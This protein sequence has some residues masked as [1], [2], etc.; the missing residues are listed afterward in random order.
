MNSALRYVNS[1]VYLLLAINIALKSSIHD[2]A[3]VG[4]Y[5]TLAALALSMGR[6]RS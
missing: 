4:L 2:L 3:S 5:L 6:P 1:M